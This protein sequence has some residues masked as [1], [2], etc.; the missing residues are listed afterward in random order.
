MSI[1]N[2]NKKSYPAIRPTRDPGR[3]AP[4][5]QFLDFGAVRLFISYALLTFFLHFFFTYLLP[6]LSFPLRTDP[7]RF[8]ARRYKR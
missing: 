2:T 1:L 6:Y 7:V 4:L 8:Q 3:N 5:I